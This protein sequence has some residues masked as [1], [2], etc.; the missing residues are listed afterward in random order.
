[1]DIEKLEKIAGEAVERLVSVIDQ[2]TDEVRNASVLA[3]MEKREE[4][5]SSFDGLSFESQQAAREV[6]ADMLKTKYQHDLCLHVEDI[7]NLD[8]KVRKAFVA[9]E[10]EEPRAAE[11]AGETSK[12]HKTPIRNINQLWKLISVTIEARLIELEAL[13]YQDSDL[14]AWHLEAASSLSSLLKEQS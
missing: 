14:E 6:L 4:Q 10:S 1:M 9:L 8:H 7:N 3:L 13:N 11:C 12:V 5:V 2:K